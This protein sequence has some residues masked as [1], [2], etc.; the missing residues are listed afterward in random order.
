MNIPNKFGAVKLGFE[1]FKVFVVEQ[2]NEHP[3]VAIALAILFPVAIVAATVWIVRRIQQLNQPI[4]QD[5]IKTETEQLLKTDDNPTNSQGLV[6]PV[7]SSEKAW[8]KNYLYLGGLALG[9]IGAGLTIYSYSSNLPQASTALLS[10]PLNILANPFACEQMSL[11]NTTTSPIFSSIAK[12]TG[13]ILAQGICAAKSMGNTSS[14]L[15]A[16]LSTN[17]AQIDATVLLNSTAEI[18]SQGFC[19]AKLLGNSSVE[20]TKTISA[21]LPKINSKVLPIIKKGLF[22]FADKVRVASVPLVLSAVIYDKLVPYKPKFPIKTSNL[23]IST[24]AKLP[25]VGVV[26]GSFLGTAAN[27]A[28]NQSLFEKTSMFCT[29]LMKSSAF[30]VVNGLQQT[31][32]K[33]AG[34]GFNLVPG[35]FVL[36]STY[37]AAKNKVGEGKKEAEGLFK[38]AKIDLAKTAVMSS[39]AMAFKQVLKINKA[40]FDPSG[41]IMLKAAG[42]HGLLVSQKYVSDSSSKALMSLFTAYSIVTDGLFILNTAGCFH[43]PVDIAAGYIY[44]IGA[45][46]LAN[47]VVDYGVDYYENSLELKRVAKLE[48]DLQELS[49]VALNKEICVGKNHAQHEA[50]VNAY[51][52]F[53]TNNSESDY[54]RIFEMI[55]KLYGDRRSGFTFKQLCAGIWRSQLTS[56]MDSAFE[57]ITP[58]N[59]RAISVNKKRHISENYSVAC[60]K[61]IDLAASFSDDPER[62]KDVLL[63]KLSTSLVD[64]KFSERDAKMIVDEVQKRMDAPSK[65]KENPNSFAF[66]LNKHVPDIK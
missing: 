1:E 66:F 53:L 41:H 24:R 47:R 38:S 42:L 5:E 14:D 15:T 44:A 11:V 57:S 18:V 12:S 45:A 3:I 61:A 59:Y 54:P 52:N 58:E 62:D 21:N 27:I 20:L 32:T 31:I 48:N 25:A 23:N 50:A 55:Y 28:H 35:V 19:A 30:S 49:E 63:N 43:T 39:I 60:Q 6:P 17:L 56:R 64:K 2:A 65:N 4:I 33:V 37:L 16:S 36:G 8:N 7:Q 13:D 46:A 22:S 26:G 10:N 9:V 34:A 29:P 51:T 40:Q